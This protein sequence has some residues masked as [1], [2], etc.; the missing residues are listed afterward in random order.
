[1]CGQI[2]KRIWRLTDNLGNKSRVLPEKLMSEKF[3]NEDLV[4]KM[5]W[6]LDFLND[7]DTIG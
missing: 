4:L 6:F 3:E 7:Y 5:L 1:M 2:D